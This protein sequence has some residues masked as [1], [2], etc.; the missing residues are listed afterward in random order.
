MHVFTSDFPPF[1]AN[2]L[3]NARRHRKLGRAGVND[4]WVLKVRAVQ[5]FGVIVHVLTFGGPGT[6]NIM[7]VF[8]YIKTI[9]AMYNLRLIILTEGG[10]RLIIEV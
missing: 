2:F 3:H 1:S 8:V 9:F 6:K 4:G 7:I 10:I 5:R